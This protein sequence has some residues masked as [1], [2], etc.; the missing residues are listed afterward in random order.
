MILKIKNKLKRSRSRRKAKRLERKIYKYLQSNKQVYL[1][2]SYFI[3]VDLF[4]IW[5]RPK[6]IS[7]LGLGEAEA[8][9]WDL[10]STVGNIVNLGRLAAVK[11]N[12]KDIMPIWMY[13]KYKEAT[14]YRVTLWDWNKKY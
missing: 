11:V 7:E 10:G 1:S 12:P 3:E 9:S 2:D 6:I 14:I 5:G 8:N 4:D 13:E